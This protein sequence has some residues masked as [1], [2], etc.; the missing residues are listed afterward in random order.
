MATANSILYSK[1]PVADSNPEPIIIVG[2][3]RCGTSFLA[4]V[5][6]QIGDWFIFDDLYLY[7]QAKAINAI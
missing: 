1:V 4:D 6:S 7:R 3:P 5:V 2:L